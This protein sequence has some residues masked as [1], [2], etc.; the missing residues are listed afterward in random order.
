MDKSI[1]I[2]LTA[3]QT[4]HQTEL[5]CCFGSTH[6]FKD[7]GEAMFTNYSQMVWGNI[8]VQMKNERSWTSSGA[9]LFLTR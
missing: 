8:L 1:S 9:R 7:Q 5:V 6:W 4:L 3:P 2:N